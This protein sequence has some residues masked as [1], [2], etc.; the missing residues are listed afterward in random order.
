MIKH[1]LLVK[2]S[3]FLFSFPPWI[4][5]LTA[6]IAIS[7]L[8][9]HL[10]EWKTNFLI[11]FLGTIVFFDIISRSFGYAL[12]FFRAVT[13]SF[14]FLVIVI[15]F[16]SFTGFFFFSSLSSFVFL[17]LYF[18][19]RPD[20]GFIRSMIL[21]GVYPLLFYP[22]SADGILDSYLVV[23]GL[24][25]VS[26]GGYLFLL[27]REKLPSLRPVKILR[28]FLTDWL[29]HD[30]EPFENEVLRYSS[31][32]E[33]DLRII[34]CSAFSIFQSSYHPGPLRRL[35]GARL[36]N[37]ILKIGESIIYAHSPTRHS[38][39]PSTF[40]DVC[41]IKDGFESLMKNRGVELGKMG[42]PDEK[43][44]VYFTCYAIP[45]ERAVILILQREGFGPDDIPEYMYDRVR[46]IMGGSRN[47]VVIDAHS[48]E[49]EHDL[50]SEKYEKDILEVVSKLRIGNEKLDPMAG[51]S[52]KPY[53]S[54][55]VCEGGI[56]VGVLKSE[57]SVAM[58]S[59]DANGM[60]YDLRKRIITAGREMGVDIVIPMTTDN[61]AKNGVGS[62][63]GFPAGYSSQDIVEIE[64]RVRDAI[65]EAL[66]NMKKVEFRY[67]HRKINVNVMGERIFKEI[68]FLLDKKAFRYSIGF[69]ISAFLPIFLNGV[70]V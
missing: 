10:S 35:G 42:Y 14:I 40:G 48:S 12:Y 28:A 50:W 26:A 53:T 11:F 22:F 36:V 41:K 19:S 2:Y 65:R 13:I 39:N 59:I 8:F 64:K 47:V 37:E 66:R 9:S 62:L 27:S 33:G 67:L 54:R 18:S 57:K 58:V 6:G 61:H 15:S 55:G 1:E 31:C 23:D 21:A 29:Y 4:T 49:P 43:R 20:S 32:S 46:D 16:W 70:V 44:G 25:I 52:F 38:L 3:K 5:S 7:L 69:I 63:G 24:G 17:F 34:E 60:T 56:R 68:N 51:F 45:F 30:P